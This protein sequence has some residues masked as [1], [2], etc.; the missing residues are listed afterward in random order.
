MALDKVTRGQAI[1]QAQ[2]DALAELARSKLGTP[3]IFPQA[4]WEVPDRETLLEFHLADWG[5]D[6]GGIVVVKDERKV[7]QLRP[8]LNSEA[9][10]SSW[11]IFENWELKDW[12]VV[13]GVDGGVL[14][15]PVYHD[16]LKN[17]PAGIGQIAVVVRPWP[18]S[19]ATFPPQGGLQSPEVWQYIGPGAPTDLANWRLVGGC[20]EVGYGPLALAGSGGTNPT[21]VSRPLWTTELRKIQTDAI[22][23]ISN[24]QSLPYRAYVYGQRQLAF[25][26]K[27]QPF[28]NAKHFLLTAPGAPMVH[29]AAIGPNLPTENY[30]RMYKDVDYYARGYSEIDLD[31]R[32]QS[33]GVSGNFISAPF[34]FPAGIDFQFRILNP[35]DFTVQSYKLWGSVEAQIRGNLSRPGG[36]Q[37]STGVGTATTAPSFPPWPRLVWGNPADENTGV[38]W[39]G[40]QLRVART[41][42]PVDESCAIGYNILWRIRLQVNNATHSGHKTATVYRARLPTVAVEVNGYTT[43]LGN[44]MELG[45][46]TVIPRV[47]DLQGGYIATPAASA[48]IAYC[49]NNSHELKFPFGT[50]ATSAG[51]T[52]HPNKN[53]WTLVPYPCY[54]V[55]A[56]G[57]I[58]AA[59]AVQK[60]HPGADAAGMA[61][62][63][64]ICVSR[65]SSGGI[66]MSYQNAPA[67]SVQIGTRVHP[68]GSFRN[69]LTITVPAG[70]SIGRAT[71]E[72]L[73]DVVIMDNEPLYYRSA[74]GGVS[75]VQVMAIKRQPDLIVGSSYAQSVGSIWNFGG[76]QF[77]F[78]ESYNETV[79]L[80]ESLP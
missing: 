70:Q 4:V 20:Q 52:D 12:R 76:A 3:Y 44:K 80:L 17:T 54:P 1:T 45:Q 42:G 72:Q 61:V 15:L 67:I 35:G 63:H 24:A 2:M 28:T 8:F 33:G 16:N 58:T 25:E 39:N 49:A 26:G 36:W 60:W 14:D 18:R 21:R 37:D 50:F 79:D 43:P 34:G 57:V 38:E 22:R 64:D 77:G 31:V 71:A 9:G 13:D 5:V 23:A 10:S 73:R 6:P 56:S 69:L 19:S 32:M 48:K 55:P 66:R 68:S 7:Y 46:M 40:G 78:A 53:F 29:S 62:I 51:T 47:G 27:L 59:T 30:I 41:P 74:S 65:L 11:E 75:V